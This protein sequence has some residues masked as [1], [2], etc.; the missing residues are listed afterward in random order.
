M[1]KITLIIAFI[2]SALLCPGQKI[3]KAEYFIDTD[4]GFGLA[5]PIPV[6]TPANDVSLSFQVNTSSLP[7]GFHM[8]VLRARDENKRWSNTRQ[9]VFYVYKIT[10][11]TASKINKAEYFIDTDPGTGLAIPIPVSVPAKDLSLTFGVNTSGMAE[12]FH[13][14]VLR[15]R[16]EPGRWSTTRQHV[17][18]VY[19]PLS[20]PAAKMTK[21][22][23]FI[24]TDPGFGKA[25]NIPISVPTKDVSLSFNVNTSAL[26][27]GFHMMVVRARDEKS[28]WSNTRQQVYYL[29]KAVPTASVYITGIEYFIDTDP[30]YG[31]GK[32]VT[33]AVPGKD[34]S[35]DFLVNIADLTSGNHLLYIR[36]KNAENKWSNNLI[37]AFSV[38]LSAIGEKEVVPWYKMYPNPSEGNFVIDFDDL[39]RGSVKITISDL[40]GR[41]VYSNELN[42]EIIPVSVDLTDGMYMLRVESG[43]QHFMQKLIIRR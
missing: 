36:A 43:S 20:T 13:M 35:A 41:V 17:F 18:Y 12:G 26:P 4:P 6:S 3:N 25:V 21:A 2:L 22:E 32:A 5:T 34:I 7:E 15:A 42:G 19:K 31:K 8:M 11:T 16:D 24:D 27:Q 38:I 28:Y 1:K 33:V 40:N 30:G 10:S 9:Q 29:Y 14:I 37:H 39:Q 23:Y